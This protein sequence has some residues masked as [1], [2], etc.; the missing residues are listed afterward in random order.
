MHK[1]DKRGSFHDNNHKLIHLTQEEVEVVDHPLFQRLRHICQTGLLLYVW[2]TATHTRFEHSIGVV[3]MAQM[4]LNALTRAS[5]SGQK[6][7]YPLSEAENGQAA[8]F[9]ELASETRGELKRLTRL[10]ALVHDLGHGP[11]SHAFEVFAPRVEDIEPLLDDPRLDP[12]RPLGT[13]LTRG[14][15]GRIRHEAVS[16]ILFSLIW[17]DL[18]GEPWVPQAVAVVL[19]GDDAKPEMVPNQLRPWLPFVRDIVSSAPIDADRMD[20]LLRDSRSLG[21]TYGEHEAARILKSI[22]CAKT[23]DGYRL[24]WRN[25]GVRAIE[26]FV[27]SRFHMF[28]QCYTHKTLRATELMLSDVRQEAVNLDLRII[29]TDNLDVMADDYERLGDQSFLARLESIDAPGSERLRRI[30]RDLRRRHLWKRLYDFESYDS[31]LTE[32]LL[33]EMQKAYPGERF[34]IDKLPL[35]AMKDLDRGAFL[36]RLDRRGKYSFTKNRSWIEASPIMRV[37]RDEERSRVRLFM[38]TENRH[39]DRTDPI[40][41]AAIALVRDLRETYPMPE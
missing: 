18:G 1:R 16:C 34:I 19:M 4:M 12:I 10:T 11:L 17:S 39:L 27:T 24:G 37:L 35:K 23:E 6:K 28:A 3:Y 25:S 33:E 9:H 21:V 20:Y 5:R 7:L 26:S 30:A 2:P 13:R 22:L 36:M 41:D 32:R 8:R 29:R 40:R 38:E 14:K 15:D 31:H